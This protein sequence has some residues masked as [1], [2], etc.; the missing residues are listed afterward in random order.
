MNAIELQH[1]HKEYNGVIAVTDL[2]FEVHQGEVFGLLGPNGAGKSTTIRMLMDIIKPDRGVMRILGEKMS[3]R[4]KDRIGYLPE[5]RGLYRSARVLETLVYLGQ[6]KG[7]SGHDARAEAVRWLER[8]DLGEWGRRKLNELSKGMA[9]KVQLVA[10]I[11]HR[12]DLIILDEPFSGLDP[13]NIELVKDIISELVGRGATVVLSTHQLAQAEAL[14]Q[15]LVLIN[16]GTAILYGALA[17]IRAHYTQHAVRLEATGD[18]GHLPGVQAVEQNGRGATLYLTEGTTS[19]DVLRRLVER[20]IP[21]Q[22]FELA[23]PP[24][25]AIFIAAVEG[26]AR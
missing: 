16:H 15:R 14:C 24:L 25:D 22:R 9:Q 4:L 6:L 19:Q 26:A 10:T 18:I 3:D 11:L 7:M 12:P 5:E 20:D 1:V 2:S 23:T 21:V 17:D 13:L 8:V